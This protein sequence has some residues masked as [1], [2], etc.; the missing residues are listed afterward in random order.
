MV[1]D[2]IKK[3]V[4]QVINILFTVIEGVLKERDRNNKQ[5]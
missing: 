1:D 4:R 3:V 2:K 5:V